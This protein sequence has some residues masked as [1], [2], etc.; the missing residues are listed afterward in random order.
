MSMASTLVQ[1]FDEDGTLIE[2]TFAARGR[3]VPAFVEDAEYQFIR[4]PDGTFLWSRRSLAAS[5]KRA[6]LVA[7]EGAIW[8]GDPVGPRCPWCGG[9]CVYNGNYLCTQCSWGLTPEEYDGR[10]NLL[11]RPAGEDEWFALAYLSLMTYRAK[12]D[13]SWTKMPSVADPS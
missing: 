8:Q 3:M 9:E 10:G 2:E 7:R 1:W 12:R 5:K 4:R 13:K 6:P 11:P